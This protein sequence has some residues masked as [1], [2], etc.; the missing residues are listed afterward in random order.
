MLV[1]NSIKKQKN[2]AIICAQIRSLLRYQDEEPMLRVF[3]FSVFNLKH[4]ERQI[5][6]WRIKNGFVCGILRGSYQGSIK[7]LRHSC[8]AITNGLVHHSA[9]KM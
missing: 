3:V 7:L 1:H 9:D 5:L 2:P 4:V 6:S 8:A